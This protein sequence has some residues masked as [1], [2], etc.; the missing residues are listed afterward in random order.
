MKKNDWAILL[1][2]IAYSF[3]FYH[4][5]AGLNYLIFSV[6]V[7]TLFFLKFPPLLK[8]KN[9]LFNA[10]LTLLSGAFVFVH[11]S[12]LAILANFISLFLLSAYSI[13][14][15]SSVMFNLFYSIYSTLFSCVFI[16]I[17]L[18]GSNKETTRK[19][20]KSFIFILLT[21]FVPVLLAFIFLIIYKNANPL[22][23]SYT[24]KINLDFI[25]IEWIMF[26]VVGFLVIY[27]IF[28]HQ[29][30]EVID[31]WESNLPLSINPSEIVTTKWDEKK[32]SI[33][34]F[35]L[36]NSMLA[37]INLLD[38]NYLYLGAGMPKGITHKEFVHH[39]VGMLILS[40]LLAI[41]TIL[42]FFRGNLNFDKTSKIAKNLVYLW[43]IQNLL[44]VVS[45]ALRNQMYIHEALLTYKRIGVY[46]WLFMAAVG[47]I[48]LF[49]KIFK[50]RSGWY[51]FKTNSFIAYV[52]LIASAAIN[53][54][55]YISTYNLSK[56]KHIA[57]LDKKYLISL[58]ETNLAQLYAVKN[59]KDFNT[60][61]VYHYQYNYGYQNNSQLDNNLYTFL[62]KT[63]SYN[64]KS[65]SIRK[66]RVFNELLELNTKSEIT[67]I[68]I[69][70]SY[71]STL[72]P[73]FCINNIK[74]LNCYGCRIH[75]LPE[76]GYFKKLQK[77]N[78]GDNN[79][80]SLDSFPL[81]NDLTHLYLNANLITELKELKN[82]PN[83]NVLDI[84]STN[85]IRLTDLPPLP[86][87]KELYLN[88][89]KIN[90][91]SLLEKYTLLELIELND[92]QAYPDK[93]PELKKLKHLDIK[94]SPALLSILKLKPPA[95]LEYLNLSS[96]GL[97]T[98]D[99]LFETKNRSSEA[100]PKF[101]DL[102]ELYLDNNLLYT[103][104]NIDKYTSL[105]ILTASNNHLYNISSLKKLTHLKKLL[106]NNN[107]INSLSFL[108]SLTGLKEINLSG[109][110]NL[111]V[112]SPLKN[113]TDLHWVDLSNTYF[114]D[115][116]N[117]NAEKL[118]HLD[119]RNSRVSSFDAIRNFKSLKTLSV[120]GISQKD[121]MHFKGMKLQVLTVSGT[122]YNLM[123]KLRE[124]LPGTQVISTY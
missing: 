65:Y 87:L 119:L 85:I 25:S 2:T 44:M 22:F 37:F 35:I 49:L 118:E 117:L 10:T 115:L 30:I 110:Q 77:L 34:L 71:Y 17:N 114:D 19:D 102:K 62:Q 33:I 121:I 14:N 45:T 58:S 60:D 8:D 84:S 21:F 76:L 89:S 54:D 98:T 40:I 3:L 41:T 56:V 53:W 16:I 68:D 95:A 67:D 111:R 93:I 78:I 73:L 50:V 61:S 38:I 39:G 9:W 31:T 116:S 123:N 63:E 27:G 47:L 69:S 13:P 96:N 70:R 43:I 11:S 124:V 100:G 20:K 109:N 74:E 32:A 83:L 26:T 59:D 99:V 92:I 36:L 107:Q 51:L 46:Y 103:L 57:S 101:N 42:Y 18:T 1:A 5:G 104:T 113:L 105:E 112:F 91:L 80:S 52:I 120:S 12:S 29:K 28:Y 106:V 94:G 66:Q 6:L 108:D 97:K 72:K 64:W 4:Q 24:E 90:D 75:S 82:T 122:N 81:L 79:L 23:A 48:I 15:R 88:K 7:I 55:G 86:Q